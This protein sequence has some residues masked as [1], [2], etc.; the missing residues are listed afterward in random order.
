MQEW[1]PLVSIVVAP[2][3]T[4][5]AVWM[6]SY[7]SVRR[8]Q[9]EKIWDRKADA[10]GAIL[11]ALHEMQAWYNEC[12]N[13]EML[14]RDVSEAVQTSRHQNYRNARLALCRTVG[15]EVW[16]LDAAVKDRTDEMIKVLDNRYESWF[17]DLD[18]GQYE[19]S[20][21]MLEITELASREL[22]RR[23]TR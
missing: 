23:R 13:D 9:S 7:F 1:L 22:N 10:Y 2:V 4:L 6:T 8:S 17:D 11:E 18:A 3:S 21:V 20:K 12:M 15:R 16:L 5:V 14:R 19:I